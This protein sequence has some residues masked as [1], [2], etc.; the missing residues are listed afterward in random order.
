MKTTLFLI[1]LGL[2]RGIQVSTGL[3][4]PVPSHVPSA[5]TPSPQ[6]PIDCFWAG[7]TAMAEFGRIS[8]DIMINGPWFNKERILTTFRAF[9]NVYQECWY[10]IPSFFKYERCLELVKLELD[11]VDKL[12]Y[13]LDIENYDE[14]WEE[15]M[16]LTPLEINLV[17]V[18][19]NTKGFLEAKNLVMARIGWPI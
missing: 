16:S 19:L 3:D 6:G 7:W 1:F 18:C 10:K 8:Q 17:N 4:D 5:A 11:K 13:L 15:L 14:A 9:R 12:A 2:A